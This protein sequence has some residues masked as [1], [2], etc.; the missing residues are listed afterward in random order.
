MSIRSQRLEPR[1]VHLG[2]LDDL[3]ADAELEVLEQLDELGAVD[4]VDQGG[5]VAGGLGLGDA[6]EGAGGEPWAPRGALA[7]VVPQTAGQL[8]V[9]RPDGP[10][11]AG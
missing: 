5:A 6:G 10:Q 7:I 2:D 11:S 4:E 3:R 9:S 1:C 8:A